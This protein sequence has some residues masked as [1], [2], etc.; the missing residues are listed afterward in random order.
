MGANAWNGRIAVLLALLKAMRPKQWAKNVFVFAGVFFD[1]KIFDL[2]ML[3]RSVAAF[4]I[5]CLLSSAIYLVN[6]LVDMDKDRLHPTKRNRPLASGTLPPGVAI[7]AASIML[8][9]CLPLAFI[10][11]SGF[12]LIATIYSLV[13]VLYSFKLKHIVIIDVMTIA[14]GF[15]LRVL[16]GTTAVPVSRFSPWLYVCTTLLA[17]FIAVNRRSHELALLEEKA[18]HHRAS[19]EDYTPE[20]LNDMTSLVTATALVAYSFYTFSA[21]NLPEN[22]SM[23]LTI[24]FVMYGIFRYLY[25][26]R[27]KGLGGAPEDLF[28]SDRPLLLSGL[29]WALTAGLVIYAG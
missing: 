27:V 19:L 8:I 14:A 26:I 13:M 5:F 15:V 6:D 25:L 10:M 2:N 24:P 18:N 9:V 23:M 28:L 16:G 11:N 3:L 29:L 4:A 21:P 12:G 7:V 22:H 20:F 1:G 17:L